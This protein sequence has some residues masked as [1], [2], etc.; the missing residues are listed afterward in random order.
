MTTAVSNVLGVAR[1]PA[2]RLMTSERAADDGAQALDAEQV[3]EP[4]LHVDHVLDGDEWEVAAI[5]NP[6]RRI[7]RARPGRPATAAEHV[8][9]DD[10][11]AVGV[12]GLARTDESF[13]PTRLIVLV[14]AGEV[15]VAR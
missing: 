12:D 5:G 14:V 11:Q 7:D 9:A 2:E 1:R 4:L 6:G 8:R 10:E 15:R 13:P 3:D